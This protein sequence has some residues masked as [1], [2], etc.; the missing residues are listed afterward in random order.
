MK[1]IKTI[2]IFVMLFSV[3]AQANARTSIPVSVGV[4]AYGDAVITDF[5]EIGYAERFGGLFE[6]VLFPLGDPWTCAVRTDLSFMNRD[7]LSMR[8]QARNFDPS[9]MLEFLIRY[10]PFDYGISVGAGIGL[11]MPGGK[12]LPGERS[13]RI[14]NAFT[15]EP[16]V[17]LNTSPTGCM[18]IA[19]PVRALLYGNE[20]YL[21]AGLSCTLYF[22]NSSI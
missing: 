10:T 14:M 4:G 11:Y 13:I 15:F 7:T 22:G 9:S 5:T 12:P 16:S 18:R 20:C 1:K 19:I 8:Y 17:L 21:M 6:L 3:L 2:A